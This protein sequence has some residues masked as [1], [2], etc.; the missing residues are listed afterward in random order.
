[1][2]N[3]KQIKTVPSLITI[4]AVCSHYNRLQPPQGSGRCR[5]VC[6]PLEADRACETYQAL[7]NCALVSKSWTLSSHKSLFKDIVFNVNERERTRDLV[8]PSKTSL[9][10][11]KSLVIDVA[12]QSR[13]RGSITLHLLKAFSACP[14]GSLHIEGG[15]FSLRRRPTLRAC[16]DTLSGRLSDLVF[17]FCLFEPEPLRDILAIQNTEANITFLACDQHHPDDPARNNIIWRPVNQGPSRTLC[18]MG[19]DDMPC[20]DFLIDLSRLSVLFS[21]LEVDFYEDGERSDATQNLIDVSAGVVSFLMVNVISSTLPPWIGF[22]CHRLT[23]DL[24]QLPDDLEVFPPPDLGRCVDLSELVLNMK[25]S[26]SCI[27]ETPGAVLATLL[28]AI[29]PTFLGSLSKLR[30]HMS[31]SWLNLAE[32][33]G[34]PGRTSTLLSP[35]SQRGR[36]AHAARTW[37]LS[38]K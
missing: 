37:S 33:V 19:V 34:T 29:V 20:D 7:K 10:L 4:V 17:R 28:E 2:F 36:R 31:G 27:V 5:P 13:R 22:P 16:F 11:V 3:Y 25:G 35:R 23:L 6:R 14:L 8:L 18:V 26:Y 30:T 15:S 24:V 1:M 38:W 32:S 12:P 9:R 21:R